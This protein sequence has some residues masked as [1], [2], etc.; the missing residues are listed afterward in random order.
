[1]SVFNVGDR[2]A[3]EWLNWTSSSKGIDQVWAHNRAKGTIQSVFEIVGNA[4]PPSFA[5]CSMRRKEMYD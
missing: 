2:V 3:F 5:K 1:M 4:R